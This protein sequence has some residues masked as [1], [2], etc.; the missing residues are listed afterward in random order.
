MLRYIEDNCDEIRITK[1]FI[2][3]M[4]FHNRT[5]AFAEPDYDLYKLPNKPLQSYSIDKEKEALNILLKLK[6]NGN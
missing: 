2:E 3:I 4:I 1:D 5:T 6:N